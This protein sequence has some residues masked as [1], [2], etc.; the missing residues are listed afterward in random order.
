MKV[1]WCGRGRDRCIYAIFAY[2]NDLPGVGKSTNGLDIWKLCIEL[3]FN[4]AFRVQV[5]KN[6]AEGEQLVAFAIR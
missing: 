6:Y 2:T 3:I 4:Q 1:G 5:R